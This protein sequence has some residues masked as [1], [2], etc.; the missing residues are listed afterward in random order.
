VKTAELTRAQLDALLLP[1]LGQ[2]LGELARVTTEPEATIYARKIHA[3]CGVVKR[4]HGQE[5][6]FRFEQLLFDLRV[7]RL[8]I[9]IVPAEKGRQA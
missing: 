4:E 5:A 9:Q 8:T 3:A 6:L 1:I 7:G 2:A